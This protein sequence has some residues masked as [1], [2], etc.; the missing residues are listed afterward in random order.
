M[1]LT[2]RRQGVARLCQAGFSRLR[3]CRVVGLSRNASPG[4]PAEPQPELRASILE[5]ARANPRYR[6]RRIHALLTCTNLKP[7]HRIWVSE[8]LRLSRRVRKRLNVPKQPSPPLVR[9]NQARCLDFVHDRLHNGRQFRI[10]AVLDCFTRECLLLKAGT[11]YP[12][13]A[14]QSDLNW[15]FLV[16]GMPSKLVSDNGPEFRSLKLPQEV[17]TGYIQPCHPWQNGRVESFFDKLRGRTA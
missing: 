6:F 7:V 16:H 14:V 3:S 15:L 10:L 1:S 5:L 12:G 17:E 8:R 11:H 4:E 13:C 9:P 2:S